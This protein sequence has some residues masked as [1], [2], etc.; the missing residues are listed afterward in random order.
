MNEI[1]QYVMENQDK[2]SEIV[3]GVILV[4][5]MVAALTPAKRD[6]EVVSSVDKGFRKVIEL[7]SGAGH[8]NLIAPTQVD[9]VVPTQVATSDEDP[10]EALAALV[11][12]FNAKI[13]IV[14]KEK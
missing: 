1:F 12:K 8:R 6:D 5:R 3:L 7:I 10:F 14:P 11:D 13:V 4:A 9:S 2:L